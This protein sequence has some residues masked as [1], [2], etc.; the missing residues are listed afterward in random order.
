MG[1]HVGKGV[2]DDTPKHAR[3]SMVLVPMDAKGL[4][5]VRPL[6]VFG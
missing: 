3:H 2:T 5:T 4:T 6:T 1:R